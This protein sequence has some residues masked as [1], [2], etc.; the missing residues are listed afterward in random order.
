MA[1]Q[2]RTSGQPVLRK[3]GAS[4]LGHWTQERIWNPAFSRQKC[5]VFCSRFS[6]VCYFLKRIFSHFFCDSGSNFW[7]L[8]WSPKWAPDLGISIG[9]VL[10]GPN[11]VPVLGPILGPIFGPQNQQI[12]GSL[13]VSAAKNL[14]PI[15][16]CLGL[17]VRF[18]LICSGQR[19]QGPRQTKSHFS[20]I[21]MRLCSSSITAS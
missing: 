8:F 13:L 15:F 6:Y 16:G 2:L 14:G 18:S 17:A 7:P 5:F 9:N 1:I 3:G 4:G 20:S 21:W 11:L 12:F 19:W 10:T